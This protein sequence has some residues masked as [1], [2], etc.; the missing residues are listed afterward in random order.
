MFLLVQGFLTLAQ[1][2]FN[3]K[4][5]VLTPINTEEPWD[6]EAPYLFF[7]GAQTE[8]CKR[9]AGSAAGSRGQFRG[10]A[11]L[12]CRR[13]G[14]GVTGHLV[15]E[16]VG[17]VLFDL[18]PLSLL[19]VV[20]R[21]IFQVSL[22]LRTEKKKEYEQTFLVQSTYPLLDVL[23]QW[24]TMMLAQQWVPRNGEWICSYL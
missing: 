16:G 22:N 15:A 1:K 6:F 3:W 8:H 20:F 18:L 17:E 9:A 11:W 10:G 12:R 5:T 21:W 19:D 14:Q 13:C 23:Y 24:W 7:V 2:D 4:D